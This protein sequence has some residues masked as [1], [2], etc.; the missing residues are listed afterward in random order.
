MMAALE[1]AVRSC[2]VV[3]FS[4]SAEEGLRGDTLGKLYARRG[5]VPVERLYW[6]RFEPMR[7]VA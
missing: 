4:M 3:L 6:K 5:F 1:D 7:D 2:G